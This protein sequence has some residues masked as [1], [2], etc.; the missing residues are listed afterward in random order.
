[1]TIFV[2]LLFLLFSLTSCENLIFEK[3]HL[4]DHNPATNNFFF[5]GN[6]PVLNSTFAYDELKTYFQIR[7]QESGF[8]FPSQFTLVDISMLW[9]VEEPF[10]DYP[11]EV[12]FWKDPSN[13][14]LGNFT[15]WP[16]GYSGLSLIP[17][18]MTKDMARAL[19]GKFAKIDDVYSKVVW[20]KKELDTKQMEPVV[21]YAHCHHGCDRTGYLVGGYRMINYGLTIEESYSKN[22]K[23]CGR[24][25][26]YMATESMKWFCIDLENRMG[27]DFGDCFEFASCVPWDYCSINY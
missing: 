4:V 14:L 21:F 7:A 26:D 18:M 2:S 19:A 9:L 22:L 16:I 20:L 27:R 6:L 1:M 13:H 3:V 8:D 24:T 11:L 15:E 17:S 25:Q 23:E 10:T 5:R 12:N